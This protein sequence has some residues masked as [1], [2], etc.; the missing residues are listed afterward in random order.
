[1][2]K[3]LKL[4][5][6]ADVSKWDVSFKV[7]DEKYKLEDLFRS[8]IDWP[9]DRMDKFPVEL[10]ITV[11]IPDEGLTINGGNATEEEVK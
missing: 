3:S 7:S 8:M 4:V 9:E 1:M 2:K 6:M 5:G 10:A 11:K